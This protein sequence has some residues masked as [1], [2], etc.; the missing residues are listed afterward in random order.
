MSGNSVSA[1]HFD[2][3]QHLGV[4]NLIKTIPTPLPWDG[5]GFDLRQQFEV[6]AYGQFIPPAGARLEDE[7]APPELLPLVA[8]LEAYGVPLVFRVSGD[9]RGV[10]LSCGTWKIAGF[11][12]AAVLISALRGQFPAINLSRIGPTRENETWGGS[13]AMGVPSV[14]LG[15]LREAPI[16]R[17][18]RGLP[19]R[20]WT[21]LVVAEPVNDAVPGLIRSSAIAESRNVATEQKSDASPSPMADQYLDL[22][23]ALIK[24]SLTGSSIGMWHYCAYLIAGADDVPALAGL[25]RSMF[26]AGDPSFE[27]MQTLACRA[28]STMANGWMLPD[29]EGEPGPGQYRRMLEL[30]SIVTSAELAQLVQ[31][32]KLDTPGIMV[33]PQARFDTAASAV[34]DGDLPLRLGAVLLASQSLR[35]ADGKTT[36]VSGPSFEIKTDAL[37]K[38]VFVAGTTGSGKTNTVRAL[39]KG[40]ANRERHFMVIEPAKTEYRSFINTIEMAKDL[41]VY[42]MGNATVSPFFLNPFEATL[43]TP[44]SLHL[45]LLKSLFTTSFGMWTP[46]PQILERCLQAVYLDKG[47][48]LVGGGNTRSDEPGSIPAAAWPT[49]SDLIEKVEEILPTLGYDEKISSDMRASLT[50][51]LNGLCRG[52][53]GRMLNTRDSSDFQEALKHNVV[54][55]LE[56]IADDDEKAFLMGLLMIRLFEARRVEQRVGQLKHILVI[57]EA[58]RIL[59]NVVHTGGEESANPRGKAVETFANLLSEMR[60][61][62]QGFVIADQVPVKLAPDVIKNSNLKIAHRVVARDDRDVLAGCMA[63]DEAQEKALSILTTGQCAVFQ[64]G[65]D[66]PLIVAIDEMAESSAAWPSD[67]EVAANM[68]EHIQRAHP[69]WMDTDR[70]RYVAEDA[71]TAA[72]EDDVLKAAYGRFVQAAMEANPTTGRLLTV[73]LAQAEKHRP[74]IVDPDQFRTL[75]GARIASWFAERRGRQRGLSYSRMA[76]FDKALQDLQH[77][78]LTGDGALFDSS[79]QQFASLAR[80]TFNRT[81]NPFPGCA[82]ICPDHSCFYREAVTD[83]LQASANITRDWQAAVQQ[84]DPLRAEKQMLER[85]AARLVGG[86]RPPSIRPASLCLAQHLLRVESPEIQDGLIGSLLGSDDE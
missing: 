69:S 54:F 72:L 45:D 65:E 5:V 20:E 46:L 27:P 84:S 44:V 51:R 62:G 13:L 37:V 15:L 26:V 17:V 83:V 14:R 61:Y 12:S 16:D 11:D 31:F 35:A 30:S 2:Y 36:S 21:I 52:A 8:T 78:P 22:L 29:M 55:E 24:Q 70:W 50:T 33:R 48:D 71:A 19:G 63:M 64:E 66:A 74:S 53:K 6:T 85:Y 59:S 1:A 41:R 77:V 32:P 3:L 39:L 79:L 80:E 47:W 23:N 76:R 40:L 81:S 18:I 58:H 60:A 34:S 68:R 38:H 25:W 43:G 42:T 82:A 4:G 56:A 49:L 73:A 86:D 9:Q 10:R 7:K 75:V 28:A 57:E 67:A